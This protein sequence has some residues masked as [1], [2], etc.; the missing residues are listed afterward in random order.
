MKKSLF[1]KV[2][3]FILSVTILLG[4]FGITA[5]AATSG[6]NTYESNR[7]T[8]SSLQDMKDLV[9][10]SSYE[11][12]LEEHGEPGQDLTHLKPIRV[13]V[14]KPVASLSNGELVI[15]SEFCQDAMKENAD[16][17]ANF[18]DN[19]S[20]SIYLPASGSTTWSFDVD[21]DKAGYYYLKIEYYSCITSESSV[22]AIERKLL[23]DGQ[24][25]FDESRNITLDKSWTYANIETSDPVQTTKPDGTSTKYVRKGDAYKKVVTVIKDGYETVTTYTMSQDLNGNSMAPTILQSPEWN[26]YFCQDSTGYYQGY[27]RFYLSNGVGK[28]ITLS[29]EREPVIIKSIEFLPYNPELNAVPSYDDVK[30]EYEANGYEA[31]NGKITTIQAEFPDYVSDASVYPTNDKTS[32][33]TYPSSSS[34]LLYNVIG[35]NSYNSIGQWAAYKFTVDSTGLYKLGMRYLQNALQGMFTCRTIKLS[36][37]IY[38]LED[39]T[40]E[41]PF[42]EAYDARFKYSDDWQSTFVGDSKGN[43]FE[44]YFEEGVEYT[45]YLECSLG[46]LKDLIRAAEN[47][48]SIINECYLRILQ[49]T[50]ATPDEFRDYGFYEIMPDVLIS[51]GEQAME[52]ERIRLELKKLC[53]TNGSHIATLG[54]IAKVLD[55]MSRNKGANVASN[56]SNLKSNLGTL[57][58]WINDSKLGTIILDSISVCPSD[59]KKSKLPDADSGFFESIWFEIKSFFSSFVTDYNNMGVTKETTAGSKVSIEVWLALGRDQSNIWRSMIDAQDGFTK[60]TGYAVKLKLV[61]DGT[62]LPSILSGKGP[63]VYMGLP[64]ATA[65]NY[66]I[67]DAITPVGGARLPDTKGNE[68]FKN[69]SYIYRTENGLEAT[70]EYRGEEGLS[71]TSMPYE[72]YV[73]GKDRP[74]MVDKNGQHIQRFANAALDTLTLLEQSYGIPQTM[75]FSMMFYRMDILAELN[76]VVPETWDDLLS[77]LPV[78]QSNNMEIGLDYVLALDFM[79]YQKG[80]NM[81]R[82]TDNP[83]Y[84]GSE[85]GL[86]S[87]IAKESFKYVCR[88]YTD[89]SFPVAYDGANRFR[90]GETPIIIG[91]YSSFYNKLV[92]Y[93]TE[94]EGLWEFC[95]VPG[96]AQYDENDYRTS[97][98]YDSIANVTATVMLNGCE[99]IERQAAWAF[100]QWQT[101][102][103]VQ[104]TYGNKMVALIGPSAKYETGNRYAINDLSWT[105]NEKEAILD[106][107]N[108]MSSIVNYPGSYY[109]ARYV[110]FAF[111]DAVAGTDPVD[112]LDEYIGQINTEITR[113]RE[114]FGLKTGKP[115]IDS[116]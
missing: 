96:V 74:D 13:D 62:L 89:Y 42:M 8:A 59:T 40:P 86:D 105:A 25:P 95:P 49:L 65:I 69:Y 19:Q 73:L 12:Y 52:L 81:W 31:A 5:G 48:L 22:S 63:D 43:I 20:T 107:I 17:W 57:G 54:T 104:S 72:D 3:C 91:D 46:S 37:G 87:D 113:K 71:F 67:R 102:E 16:N 66:A 47:S 38:G 92:V 109:I 60:Q 34:A 21:D 112:A 88:L 97:V 68:I 106:Q 94:I 4:A 32:T 58:T 90:T 93:A 82:Y 53:G 61:T 6:G 115:P 114:E 10:I 45:L 44:F 78:L 84:A 29:A 79:L 98:N 51:F 39:G 35:K 116:N 30:A 70:S 108:H 28:Q 64:V 33:A 50:G 99:G 1:Q 27:F 75:T 23:I 7:D 56:M 83:E 85:I 36:G 76:L 55:D 11:E 2:T 80:G 14:T 101:R 18:G 15:N 110:N 41:V 24:A 103:D 111:L 100:M 77:M 26:T 9:G